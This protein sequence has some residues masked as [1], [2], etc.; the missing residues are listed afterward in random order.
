MRL[1]LAG[2]L[3]IVLIVM[4]PH[5]GAS[6]QE[7]PMEIDAPAASAQR[8]GVVGYTGYQRDGTNFVIEV[9][10]KAGFFDVVLS[11]LENGSTAVKITDGRDVL[12]IEFNGPE[13]TFS[14]E[15]IGSMRAYKKTLDKTSKK[16]REHPGS[17][18]GLLRRFDKLIKVGAETA[19]AVQNSL[20]VDLDERSTADKESRGVNTTSSLSQGGCYIPCNGPWVRGSASIYWTRSACC[21]SALQ[22]AHNQC[23]TQYCIGC[24]ELRS[25]DAAC[26]FDDYFCATCGVSGRN[27]GLLCCT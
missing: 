23:W 25:C 4:V 22:D 12:I 2:L 7:V 19:A 6:A 24:C 14:V 10:T 13:G 8:L 16:W 27:C 17:D 26:G 18:K 3:T 21:A 20:L 15:H 11:Y 1:C 9:E 5:L